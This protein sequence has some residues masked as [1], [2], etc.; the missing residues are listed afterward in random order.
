MDAPRVLQIGGQ[1]RT[2]DLGHALRGAA[3]AMCDAD[4][5]ERIRQEAVVL[6]LGRD[7]SGELFL[8]RHAELLRSRSAVDAS[9]LTIPETPG[10]AGRPVSMLRRVLWKLLRHQQD[11]ITFRQNTINAQLL[12]ALEFEKQARRHEAAELRRRLDALER[13]QQPDTS[14]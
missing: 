1:D 13:G 11:W 5:A 2:A 4:L 8:D 9:K 3:E 6:A 10:P 7:A 14:S 12:Y